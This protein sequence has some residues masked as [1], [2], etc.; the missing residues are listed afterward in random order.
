[1]CPPPWWPGPCSSQW[2][3]SSQS[4]HNWT[5]APAL[6]GWLHNP[7]PL[8]CCC[9]FYTTIDKRKCWALTVVWFYLIWNCIHGISTRFK[10]TVIN[11]HS[12]HKLE[13]SWFLNLN[14]IIKMNY[15]YNKSN[16][17]CKPLLLKRL[18]Q[19]CTCRKCSLLQDQDHS[20]GS[21]WS[22]H[23]HDT[24]SQSHTFGE[25]FI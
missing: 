9:Y 1:M 8:R 25:N 16:A 21:L 15:S 5:L 12:R 17:F 10:E 3:C 23:S 13:Y 11:F 7:Q 4:W 14:E 18:S 19:C 20:W 2:R 6:C 24:L 22:G